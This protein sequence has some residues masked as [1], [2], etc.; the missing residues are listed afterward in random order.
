MK[1]SLIAL[2][3]TAAV[4]VPSIAT[5]DATLYGSFQ[6]GVTDAKNE[7]L[8]LDDISTR[9]G[10][11]GTVDLGLE[12]TR[13][14]F[15]WES[16]INTNSDGNGL[17]DLRYAYAGATGAWGTVLAGK[18][19]HPSV[20]MV[21]DYTD[22]SWNGDYATVG[23]EYHSKMTNSLAYASPEFS[24]LQF[25]VG[26]VFAGDNLS[27]EKD[28]T[29]DGYNLGVQYD[30]NG[31][32]GAVAYGNVKSGK[33]TGVYGVDQ[34]VWGLAA[35]YSGIENLDLRV[36]YERLRDKTGGS[37]V[38]VDYMDGVEGKA[39]AWNIAANYDIDNT[40]IYGTYGRYKFKPQNEENAKGTV[41]TLGVSHAMGNGAVFAEFVNYGKDIKDEGR[42]TT[43]GYILNF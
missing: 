5:A 41:Y 17:G 24:G 9:I 8:I 25:V 22:F 26:G 43:V 42:Y 2:A 10:I 34:N 35:G 33:D 11:K 13:G 37:E 36:S 28:K 38:A 30:A 15:L 16:A 12:D 19:D 23:Q 32:Y 1:K 14:I 21:S 29:I 31:F 40:S 3:V 4:A 20:G 7:S 39:N 27:E 6:M 18:I